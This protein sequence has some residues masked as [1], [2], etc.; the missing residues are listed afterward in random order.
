MTMIR[1]LMT[2][3]SSV[4]DRVRLRCAF[5][6]GRCAT[7]W[8]TRRLADQVVRHLAGLL[9]RLPAAAVAPET[10]EATQ[11]A[12][13]A[14]AAA[15]EATPAEPPSEVDFARQQWLAQAVDVSPTKHHVQLT[16]RN[17]ERAAQIAMDTATLQK[18]LDGLHEAYRAA[19][20]SPP[21]PKTRAEQDAPPAPARAL[22]I[23]H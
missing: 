22:K 15:A 20:W 10:A 16:F 18:W 7:V 14:A 8:L 21:A 12:D 19:A 6:D 23:T 5:H 4:E 9:E 1:N 3:Y 17:S 2:D 13:A 11:G